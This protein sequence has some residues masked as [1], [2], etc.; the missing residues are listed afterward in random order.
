MGAHGCAVRSTI[1]GQQQLGAPFWLALEAQVFDGKRDTWWAC[2]VDEAVP[3]RRREVSP[4]GDLPKRRVELAKVVQD[5]GCDE[6][7]Q[8]I[9]LSQGSESGSV[10]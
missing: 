9:W 4:S 1:A 10:A 5:L 7:G 2:A 6:E 8:A 3:L